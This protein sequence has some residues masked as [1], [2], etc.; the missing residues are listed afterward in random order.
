MQPE[1]VTLVYALA[2]EVD[3]ARFQDIENP[4]PEII[5][6]LETYFSRKFVEDRIMGY[7]FPGI[8]ATHITANLV[9]TTVTPKPKELAEQLK[10]PS[11]GPWASEGRK[12]NPEQ[13]AVTDKATLRH[14]R[15]ILSHDPDARVEEPTDQA[16]AEFEA[17]VIRTY[18][19]DL[20][21]L[22]RAG[23]WEPTGEV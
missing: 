21:H 13:L 6:Y 2:I 4:K 9:R 11:W 10:S 7:G 18:G 15:T 22:Y 23:N 16:Y 19:A 5:K 17:W 12:P 20:W 14:L 8:S 3:I 1:K